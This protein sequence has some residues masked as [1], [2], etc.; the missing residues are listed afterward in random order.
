VDDRPSTLW[1]DVVRTRLRHRCHD[2]VQ[3]GARRSQAQS[4]SPT[5]AQE[6]WSAELL[7]SQSIAAPHQEGSDVAAISLSVSVASAAVVAPAA[8]PILAGE[9]GARASR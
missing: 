5:A 7:L 9:Q 2:E 3:L 6:W 1:T 8:A 4:F